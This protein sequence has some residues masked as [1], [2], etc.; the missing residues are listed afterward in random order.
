MEFDFKKCIWW[1]LASDPKFIFFESFETFRNFNPNY[2]RDSKNSNY[3]NKY[4]CMET[5][6]VTSEGLSPT[7]KSKNDIYEAFKFQRKY[8]KQWR[9]SN[10]SQ[11][12]SFYNLSSSI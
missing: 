6:L 3:N 12:L 4:I 1:K 7:M 8:I 9:G 5:T 10:N 2:I 11:F